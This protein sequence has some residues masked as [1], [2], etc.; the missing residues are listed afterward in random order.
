MLKIYITGPESTGKTALAQSLSA[1]YDCPWVPEYARQYL[2]ETGG[3]YE[4]QDLLAISKGQ[5]G[6]EHSFAQF[7]PDILLVDTD[8]AVMHIWSEH[9][10][11]RVD[12]YIIEA[13]KNQ[14]GC[15][16]LLCKPDLPWEADPLR[17]HPNNRE[18]LFELY[19]SLL[20][21]YKLNYAVVDGKDSARIDRAIELVEKFRH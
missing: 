7:A 15:L 18:E 12:E 5:S 3:K 2:A 11:G 19:E 17:E 13:L 9:K 4:E 21:K 10:Y 6:L 14:E 20:Q 16:H 8:Q 1:H